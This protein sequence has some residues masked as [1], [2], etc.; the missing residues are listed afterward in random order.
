MP[1]RFDMSARR[2]AL[3]ALALWAYSLTLIGLVFYS[4]MEPA[5]GY[6]IL[7][8]GWLSPALLNFAWYANPFFLYGIARLIGH[9][10]PTLSSA[11]AAVLALDTVRFERMPVDEG[12]GSTVLYGYGWGAIVWL[13]S[14][15]LLLVAVGL[16]RVETGRAGEP[17]HVRDAYRPAGAALFVLTLGAALLLAAQNRLVANPAEQARLVGV[18]FKRGLVC[19]ETVPAVSK[20]LQSLTGPLEIVLDTAVS[21]AIHPFAQVDDLLAWGVPAVRIGGFDYALDAVAGDGAVTS[22]AAVGAPAAVLRVEEENDRSIRAMLVDARTGGTVF[23]QRWVRHRLP[24]SE[25][26]YCPD[27][28]AYPQPDQQPR[29]LLVQALGLPA[30]PAATASDPRGVAEIVE[31][32]IVERSDD[33]DGDAAGTG[34]ASGPPAADPLDTGCPSGVGWDPRYSTWQ[35]GVSA[36]FRIG[37]RAYHVPH[38]PYGQVICAVEVAYLYRGETVHDGYLLGLEAR[39]L[40][41]FRPLWRTR[42]RLRGVPSSIRPK[43]LRVRSVREQADGLWIALADINTGSRLLVRTPLPTQRGR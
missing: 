7:V 3:L 29:Q 27:Y 32:V 33:P 40:R 21:R 18:A 1:P 25:A 20:A 36:A 9:G 43:A 31:G 26:R 42:V 30:T 34:A 37:D 13:L 4:R 2:L 15:F 8:T 38:S 24:L 14:I 5:P 39:S 12:G 6:Q 35:Y 23:D 10:T 22:T 41:D 17:P 16:R 11:I 19:S 28:H